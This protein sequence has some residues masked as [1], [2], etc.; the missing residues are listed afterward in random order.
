[1]EGLSDRVS[2]GIGALPPTV[3]EH[4]GGIEGESIYPIKR[5]KEVIG[6]LG[7]REDNLYIAICA[8]FTRPKRDSTYSL[9]AIPFEEFVSY[10]G[11][12]NSDIRFGTFA[13]SY[14]YSN[15]IHPM[16]DGIPSLSEAL[17][18]LNSIILTPSV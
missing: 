13:Y 18:R 17:G 4:L 11:G 16:Y 12:I 15:G 14:L 2:F 5:F 3:H 7:R 10:C 9:Y 1:M 6:Y 8:T